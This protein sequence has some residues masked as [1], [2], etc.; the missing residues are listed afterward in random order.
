MVVLSEQC[1]LAW[2]EPS[3]LWGDRGRWVRLPG[4]HHGPHPMILRFANDAFMEE[5]LAMLEQCPYRLPEWEARPETWRDPMPS[6]V[7][8]LKTKPTPAQKRLY[9]GAKLILNQPVPAQGNLLNAA[10][11]MTPISPRIAAPLSPVKLFQP[12][13][14]RYYLVAASLIAREQS[15]P[16]YKPDPGNDERATFVVR[17]LVE[18]AD[19]SDKNG[20]YAYVATPA[21]LAWRKVSS[22][23]AAHVDNRRLMP[24]EE[25]HA[26][27][28]LHYPDRCDRQRRILAGFIPVGKREAWLGASACG[29]DIKAGIASPVTSTEGGGRHISDIFFTQVIEPWRALIE[30]AAYLKASLGTGE[31]SGTSPNEEVQEKVKAL[32][33]ARDR[34]Q[35][36]SWYI[37]VDFALFLET[38]LPRVW[39]ALSGQGAAGKTTSAEQD[40][41]DLLSKTTLSADSFAALAVDHLLSAN[42]I[43]QKETLWE[44][45]SAFWKLEDKL[46]WTDW[47]PQ[48]KDLP[49]AVF[50][51][52]NDADISAEERTLFH[53][54]RM[55]L[56]YGVWF[57][58]LDMAAWLG[59]HFPNLKKRALGKISASQLST[60]EANAVKRLSGITRQAMNTLRAIVGVGG[61]SRQRVDIKHSLAEALTAVKACEQNLNTITVP[62]DRQEPPEGVVKIPVIDPMWPGFLFPLADPDTLLDPALSAV[63]P[64]ISVDTT[65]LQPPDIAVAKLKALA[66]RIDALLPA[67]SIPPERATEIGATPF[68]D[69]RH[70]RFVLRCVFQ[71]PNCEPLFPALVSEATRPLELAPFFDP[72]APARPVRIALPMD[73]SPAGLRKYKKNAVFLISDMLCGK[74]SKIKKMTLADLV[75]SVL[76]WPF[77][78]DLPNPEPAGGC[79]SG[80]ISLGMFCSL[81][82]PIVTLCA[83]ILMIIMVKLFDFIFRWFP[84]LFVCLPIP[85]FTGKDNDGS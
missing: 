84:Y 42:C 25:Q 15:Y 77:H 38:Y 48:R 72:D 55:L 60:D 45:L 10:V 80:G 41:I 67:P 79:E 2:L 75:L 29:T 51:R 85:N 19:D 23:G 35:T 5:L 37:L 36:G 81:S 7:P 24:N 62:F 16:D 71:R 8:V 34:F 32:K 6:P 46:A 31:I 50:N 66:Q 20:E 47:S 30:Q 63:A 3:P 68:L 82:I 58:L 44:E 53:N 33:A 52:I 40:L 64:P 76:P 69:H 9:N 11:D 13:H 56:Q 12:A 4:Q 49:A 83:L 18:N 21:G 43:I 1:R 73:I 28:P 22:H 61:L 26:L 59:T 70:T 54:L 57:T 78:K 14:N 39:Q 27:F 17:A 65:G 74:I